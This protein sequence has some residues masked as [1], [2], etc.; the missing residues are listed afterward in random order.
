MSYSASLQSIRQARA[1]RDITNDH[2]YALQLQYQSLLKKQ[3]KGDN[4]KLLFIV[5]QL[6]FRFYA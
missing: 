3:K 4:A 1:D 6:K 5:Y 2:L